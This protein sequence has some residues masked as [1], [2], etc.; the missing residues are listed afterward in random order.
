MIRPYFEKDDIT[1]YHGDLLDVLPQLP[2][3][4][5]DCVVT[6]PPYLLSFMG[7]EWD[8]GGGDIPASELVFRA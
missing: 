4:S 3:A 1:I 2:P 7:K 6:D 5:I 8:K